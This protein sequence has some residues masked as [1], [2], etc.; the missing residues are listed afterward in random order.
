MKLNLYIG[1]KEHKARAGWNISISSHWWSFLLIAILLVGTSLT[2][3]G[4][5]G[6]LADGWPPFQD[7][8][9][10][11]QEA[12][13]SVVDGDGNIIITGYQ[14]LSA[15]SG[16]EYWTLKLNADRTVAWRASLN[17]PGYT[18]QVVA[19]VLDSQKN[20]I[21]TGFVSN[22]P[23]TDVHTIKYAK[24]DGAVVWART[25][26]GVADHNDSPA[27]IAVD[28]D[29]N[30]YVGG[31]SENSS[32]NKDYLIL[33]YSKD[34]TSTDPPLWQQ[35][36]G[37]TT[38]ADT[39][40]SIAVAASGVVVTGNS[41]NGTG[42]GFLT[43]K[44][45][46]DGTTID[47]WER[48]YADPNPVSLSDS[49]Q[50]VKIDSDGNVI[51]EGFVYHLPTRTDTDIYT[52]KLNGSTGAVIWENTYNGGF[53]DEPNGLF[54][55]SAT[56]DALAKNDVYITGHSTSAGGRSHFYTAK[57]NA[58][59]TKVWE[60]PFNSG[61][62]NTDIPTGIV[63]DADAL[64]AGAVFVTGYTESAGNYDF[65][66]L[67]YKKDNGHL[68]WQSTFNSAANKSDKPVGIG[69]SPSGDVYVTGWS[70]MTG[71]KPGTA[72]TATGGSETTVVTALMPWADNQWAGYYV[73][74]T[75]GQNED[76]AREILSNTSTETTSTITV[77]IPFPVG[78][79]VLNGDT[80][81][82]YDKDDYDYQVVKYDKGL[83]NPPT[84]LQAVT[85]SNSEIL[86]TWEDNSPTLGTVFKIEKCTVST[87][88]YTPC[89][90]FDTGNPITTTVAGVT[91]YS[92][93]ALEPD[94]FYYYRV[95]AFKDGQESKP[96]NVAFAV[97]QFVTYRSPASRFSYASVFNND[98][99]A[100]NIAVGPDN[101]PVVTGK[102]FG[103]ILNATAPSFDY[104]TVKL[105]R[106]DLS[107]TPL[108]S[109]EYDGADSEADIGMCVTVDN[110]NQAIV[111]G[112]S[113][114]YSEAAQGN[115]NSIY[116]IKYVLNPSPDPEMGD[117]EQWSRQY[118]GPGAINDLP[119]AVASTTDG[120]NNVVVIGHGYN[121]NGN[122]DVYVIKY[123]SDG[124]P[125]WA[126]APPDLD[127]GGH[128]YPTA[129]AFDAAG[130]VF[131]TGYTKKAP[132]DGPDYDIFT[133][134]YCGTTNATCMGKTKGQI[135]WKDIYAGSGNG[136]DIAYGLAVDKSGDVYVTGYTTKTANNQD[137]ITI[138]YRGSPTGGSPP[139]TLAEIVWQKD[140]V[141]GPVNG[142]D[143]AV[144]IKV[145]PIDGN[146]V[147]AGTCQTGLNDNDFRVIRYNKTNGAVI[148]DNT[149]KRLNNDDYAIDMGIDASGSVYVVGNTYKDAFIDIQSVK[150]DYNGDI[151]DAM[152]YSSKDGE[153]VDLLR[154]DQAYSV[155]V[156][157]LGEAFIAGA[158]KNTT[159]NEDYIALKHDTSD[160]LAPYPLTAVPRSDCTIIDLSWKA[161]TPGTAFELTRMPGSVVIPLSS[162]TTTY[163][164][165]GLGCNTTYTYTIVATTGVAPDK[166]Y[167][168]TVPPIDATTTLAPP[169]APT[170]TVLSDSAID[171]SWDNIAGNTGYI[172]ERKQG[173]G[174]VWGQVP[175][176]A[177]DLAADTVIYH[178][179]VLSSGTYYYYRLKVK[180]LSGI[181][182][183]GPD[184]NKRTK[185]GKPGGLSVSSVT[186]SS[187]NIGWTAVTGAT[188]YTIERQAPDAKTV[189]GVTG[190]SY[191]D[192]TPALT[193]GT[194]Y[195]YKIYALN[196]SG[197]SVI[198]D[199][200]VGKTM[201]LTPTLGTPTA[202]DGT[203]TINLPVTD[204][205]TTPNETGFTLEYS[206][207]TNTDPSQCE[208]FN[209]AYWNAAWTAVTRGANGT[210]S[211]T[212]GVTTGL[213]AGRTYRFRLT[214]TL[215]GANSASSSM[216]V[217][218]P[219]IAGPTNL[220]VTN[221]TNTSLRLTWTDVIGETN[222][223]VLIN[224]IEQSGVN[225]A[226]DS[227]FYDVT[228]LT[229]GATYTFNVKPYYG[230]ETDPTHWGL[231]NTVPQTMPADPTTLSSATASSTAQIN[232][233]WASVPTANK[234]RIE[235]SADATFTTITTIDQAA[236]DGL[237]VSY[238]N[239][240]L[241]VGTRYYYR[242]RYSTNGG[243]TWSSFSNTLDDTTFPAVPTFA[244][245]IAI[246]TTQVQL[247]WLDGVGETAYGLQ[248][249]P[250]T[251]ANCSDTGAA[252]P[253]DGVD[254]PVTASGTTVTFAYPLGTFAEATKY[255]FRI[256]AYN[257]PTDYRYSS[258]G[259]PV[260]T[261][262][263]A[264]T[265]IATP[266]TNVAR[267]TLSLTWNADPNGNG[268]N[269]YFI[270]RSINNF[271]SVQ[272]NYSTTT[273][274]LPNYNIT[275]LTA[276]TLYYFRVSTKNIDGVAGVPSSV[277]SATT[278]PAI[279]T[280]SP[281]TATMSSIT[282][283]WTNV[284]GE[285]G[286]EGQS[287]QIGTDTCATADWTGAAS[288]NTT[289]DTV[290][291]TFNGLTYGPY[292]CYRVRAVNASGG[293]T[294]ADWSTP[295]SKMPLL[296]AP[297]GLSFPAPR[298]ASEINLSW[299]PV[300]GNNGYKIERSTDNITFSTL[301][302]EA[303]AGATTYQ[304]T[305]LAAGTLY[306][307]RISTKNP[308]NDYSDPCPVGSAKTSPVA[309]ASV[310][311]DVLSD[312]QIDIKWKVVPSATNYKIYKKI[313]SEAY[314][315]LIDKAVPYGTDYCGYPYATVSC[316]TLTA[317]SATHSDNADSG[318]H[319]YCY[320]M[321]AYNT[322]PF[323]S[324]ES[325]EVCNS[326]PAAG[327]VLTIAGCSSSNVQ[328]SWTDVYGDETGFELESKVWNGS[329]V[330]LAL[331]GNLTGPTNTYTDSTGIQPSTQ[332]SYRVRSYK[333][334]FDTF[335]NGID[336]ALWNQ[337]GK[338]VTGTG[339][340]VESKTGP[341]VN[342]N[343]TNG[344][345]RITAAN[346]G[347]ELYTT[348]P[349]G[350]SADKYSYSQLIYQ[351]SAAVTGDFDMRLDYNLPEGIT[352]AVNY[353]VYGRLQVNFPATTGSNVV[354]I[355]RSQ[356]Q[357][358][359]CIGIG[360]NFICAGLPTSE[361]SG[362]FRIVR[363]G[364]VISTYI[365]VDGKWAP[366]YER[367]GAS[368][369]TA[370]GVYLTQYAQR[371]EV[372]KLKAVFDN[373]EVTTARSAYSN[374]AG[375]TTLPF[376]K[377]DNVCTPPVP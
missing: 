23:Y 235:R 299:N 260:T 125:D 105:N 350:G 253:A 137:F 280:I 119:T 88:Y 198:S 126:A 33:K 360:G 258:P 117:I 24:A 3:Q 128:D 325:A 343:T 103:Q 364:A 172:L 186:T 319:Q 177:S 256:R 185:P 357:D 170:L 9:P 27:A 173:A 13:G 344:I 335:N 67:K 354:Y 80:Y 60:Q 69:L 199:P 107:S 99:M 372:V 352:T 82:I 205:N 328:L 85:Q 101:D 263:S 160:L 306:Y 326:T 179:T 192:N 74:M 316:P 154:D 217:G 247:G 194:S 229:P 374:E 337:Y 331:V 19:V 246:S 36:Y 45:N 134:K 11:K 322:S 365:W 264:P 166:K 307:Y 216:I 66:T 161:N 118:N 40:S 220:A 373:F 311:L 75:G 35:T 250:F 249:K 226:K 110:N 346:G 259:T 174:G 314:T 207:C 356:H 377:S 309:P 282:I 348:S 271:T 58:A 296:A 301:T 376:A 203:I 339:T 261:L 123:L 26:N 294:A 285:T 375:I 182:Q 167:S 176:P 218:T 180:S 355:E 78:K 130:N 28:G 49:G 279:P 268:G 140:D 34:G 370:T 286:Y 219:D 87:D 266:I 313:D 86:L 5:G 100:N 276:G 149:L 10:R 371:N 32:G 342:I 115:I 190:T 132:V 183:V 189:P 215:S 234:Y 81:Y 53:D 131:V 366:L 270:E 44:Y 72:A 245:A 193:P 196:E 305:G 265:W 122:E 254:T 298:T 255:C 171:V 308:K 153:G 111:T 62:D 178:D 148:W 22:G 367:A 59:G 340:V 291:K 187:I 338:V 152:T 359:A 233:V 251:G 95:K 7:V 227:N 353:H 89:V 108:W 139:G 318:S 336:P 361:T 2:A 204:P 195:T 248:Y 303:P 323:D 120:S 6:D 57:Y 278:V 41:R 369:A 212:Y 93:N 351:N 168:R 146:V 92:D 321:T 300:V 363:K 304:N 206:N 358:T 267:T 191:P 20:V 273:P 290:T 333:G 164:D 104:Y 12:K 83:L 241:S 94:K 208:D 297:T 98:D 47:C 15:A 48:R 43:K 96:S 293:N 231:S 143:Q 68:L 269:G 144:A 21:V 312:T 274:H 65:Q 73:M 320:K 64:A 252:W 327:P 102:I 283:N 109:Q 222:Y 332:Y 76:I 345:S 4:A 145:D 238:S 150:Y 142:E 97:A 368:T 124:T 210:S 61:G 188:S 202:V 334:T 30:V 317:K 116:T 200:L 52:A 112:L 8:N 158:S 147:V 362:T 133:A 288:F 54:I 181:S 42:S 221:V 1:T 330:R 242:V 239:T 324:V 79:P 275:G 310:S 232:L 284:I 113:V 165:T 162:G 223:R 29:D 155:T 244:Q 17:K 121:S 230:L 39:I 213:S 228:G 55:D 201:L 50:Y 51:V 287:I 237:P 31:Y 243:T 90:A 38:D 127:R 63:V 46:L 114:L 70:D 136:D 151:I 16:D 159:G 329:W 292:Y 224:G 225:L 257:D 25:Y 211:F 71:P 135:I 349:G 37:S 295:V 106:A 163:P 315:L 289:V 129:I 197:T 157:S 209:A 169:P 84:N 214:A 175:A 138:K 277:Q 56:N 184:S 262:V 156:N 341:P 347:V 77:K 141:D 240:G 18:G 91:T 302:P 14:N 236:T 281:V 272:T